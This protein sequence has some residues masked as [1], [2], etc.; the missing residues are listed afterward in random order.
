MSYSDQKLI[1][2]AHQGTTYTVSFDGQGATVSPATMT[3]TDGF[4]YG[5]LPAVERYG[6]LFEGWWTGQDGEG[7]QVTAEALVNIQSDLTLYAKWKFIVFR[8][9]TGGWV[10][11]SNPNYAVDGWQFLET[12]PEGWA[13]GEADPLLGF[14]PS[15][16]ASGTTTEI[17]SGKTNTQLIAQRLGDA[18]YA[19]TRAANYAITVDEVLY[20]DWFLPSK[21]E[22]NLMYQNLHKDGKGGFTSK[23]Y[24]SSSEYNY[25]NVWGQGF[26]SGGQ[27]P[28]SF[29][30]TSSTRPIRA[31]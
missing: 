18:D 10:F 15:Y 14:G 8:G 20:D 23:Y 26:G 3:V 5:T 30:N 17:G 4:P 22:L 12:A 19:A 28:N 1:I 6:Y 24:W 13:G 16:S 27:V 25:T 7:V 31:F 2:A 9:P 21:D 29:S 11:Y